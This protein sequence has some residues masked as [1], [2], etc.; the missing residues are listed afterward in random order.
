MRIPVFAIVAATLVPPLQAPPPPVPGVARALRV[1]YGDGRKT[2]SPVSDRGKVSWTPA[3]PR[4]TGARTAT[5]DGLPLS[6]LQFEEARDG[7]ALQV[8]LAL[9]YG[10]PQERRVQVATVRL[11]GDT[12]IRVD[13]LESFGVT[14]VTLS[15]VTLPAAQLVV[16][17]IISPSSDLGFDVEIVEGAVPAYYISVGNLSNRS[18]MMMQFRAYR[19]NTISMSGR[20]RAVG[21]LPLIE[22]GTRYLLRL[23]A[24]PN[25]GRGPENAPWLTI[26]R[27]EITSVL[28]SDGFVDGDAVVADDERALDAGTVQQLDRLVAL[29]RDVARDP[30]GRQVAALREVVAAIPI[31]VTPEEAAAVRASLGQQSKLTAAQVHMAM[32]AGM[33]NARSGVLN[34]IDQFIRDMPGAEAAAYARW[35]DAVIVKF[36]AWR[37]RIRAAR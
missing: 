13:A 12:P 18:V 20:P 21:K 14:P 32:Q 24:T 27:V 7:D 15:I 4:I 23:P 22:P 11:T 8:T 34:D 19:G 1:E 9:L 26:D 2:L 35:L 25:Q 37:A 3:F 16:P 5:E 29:L 36:D 33:R 10:K 6:A 31:T 28:W 30:S 17:S